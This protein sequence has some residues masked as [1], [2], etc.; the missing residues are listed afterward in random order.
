VISIASPNPTS[1]GARRGS[2]FG[3]GIAANA[4][5]FLVVASM[6]AGITFAL[7]GDVLLAL[8]AMLALPASVAIFRWPDAAVPIVAFVLYT[9]AAVVA[10]HFHGVPYVAAAAFPLL[11]LV[12]IARDVIFR[13]QRVVV[14]RNMVWIL[15]FFLVQFVG[16]ML[17]V[18]PEKALAECA[19]TVVEGGVIYLLL[20]NAIR[21]P[22]TVKHTV[23]ALLAAGAFMGAI[24]LTQQVTQSYED[25]Y[26][27]F[28]QL[29]S[30]ED[31]ERGET[32]V[33]GF[34]TGEIGMEGAVR[35]PRLSGPIGEKNRYAQIMAMLIPLGIFQ[36]M[37][38]RR[39]SSRRL[40]V[41]AALVLTGVGCS[42]AFSRG[43]AVG[44]GLMFLVMIGLG[45][46]RGRHIALVVVGG[47]I[48]AAIVPQYAVRL[49]T[50]F[51]AASAAAGGGVNLLT[52]DGATRGRVTE[53]KAGA[54]LFADN[55]LLGVG[56]GMYGQHYNE[57]ARLAGGKVVQGTR[58]PHSLM[59]GIPAEH[60]LLGTI[61]F[62]GILFVAF[63][64]LARARRRWGGLRPDLAHTA[65]ALILVL[66][67]YLTTSLFLHAA[68]VRYFW[69]ML[70]L[71]GA[72]SCLVAPEER[73]GLAT[74]VRL[75]QRYRRGA[76]QLRPSNPGGNEAGSG[77]P[78]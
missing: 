59:V 39:R 27:G 26:F 49:G 28:A 35:Q 52:A 19:K 3:S 75:T 64:D 66:V 43:A 36:L 51:D 56:P 69:F 22:Q 29:S 47:A 5:A 40:L 23:W 63:R 10:V 65:T 62:S 61:A 17:S 20:V 33:R 14:T 1:Q 53:M 78:G 37:G 31:R 60:G 4:L 12:P 67:V 15:A 24:T 77:P 11:L 73:S 9:N 44:L 55:P 58:Q 46:V 72:V 8:G 41:F 74:L 7:M 6:A 2:P 45:Y 21:S 34:S 76:V 25:P 32:R 48:V 38:R 18:R 16:A 30:Q 13:N 54:L 57:Y 71:A 70:G 50:I 68:Y 42:L